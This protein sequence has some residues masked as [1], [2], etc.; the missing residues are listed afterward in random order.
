MVMAK[1]WRS[2]QNCD[3]SS[4][5]IIFLDIDG[6]LNLWIS[7]KRRMLSAEAIRHLNRL[8]AETGATIVISSSWR[9]VCNVPE[10]LVRGGV[11]AQFHDDWA[12]DTNGPDRSAEITRWLEAHDNPPYVVLDDW[13]TEMRQHTERFVRINYKCGLR[14]TDVDAAIQKLNP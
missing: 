7:R 14:S 10:I 13:P 4:V 9:K 1:L 6:V 2:W 12:T 3:H 5:K 8:V 11:A